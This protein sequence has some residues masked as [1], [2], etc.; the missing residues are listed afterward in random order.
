[1]LQ[2]YLPLSTNHAICIDITGLGRYKE[3]FLGVDLAAR[4]VLLYFYSNQPITS[5]QVCYTINEFARKKGFLP[6]INVIHSDR[7]SIFSNT[8]YYECIQSLGIKTSRGSAKAYQNQVVERLNRTIK[9]RLR[10]L[11]DPSWK[12]KREKVDPLKEIKYSF[13][14]F[15]SLVNKGIE[16]YN[17][18]PHKAL[19]GLSPNQ[20]EEAL[21]LQHKGNHP[22]D[23]QLITAND[24]SA[25]AVFIRQYKQEVAEKYKGKWERFFI[26]WR[27]KQEEFQGKVV[28][29]VKENEKIAR[30]RAQ[31]LL[32]QYE[33]L[34]HQ[35]L[36]TQKQVEL[37]HQQA[38]QNQQE[39]KEKEGRKLKR[40]QAKKQDLR[41]TIKPKEFELILSLVKGA[42]GF[43]ERRR[44]KLVGIYI[45][46]LRVSNL[47]NLSV[48][49]VKQ[50]IGKG[51]NHIS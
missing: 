6:Q 35:H 49:Q 4:N 10:L 1:M 11:L 20:M 21:F 38:L 22:K 15:S 23:L 29:Q 44:F 26:E 8:E 31:E 9:D 30:L 16:Q 7:G 46:G 33:N 13:Q 27:F 34:Y 47:L 39:R 28:E 17:Q 36:K 45:T 12:K 48:G 32:D 14:E 50:L 51:Q 24:D 40:K 43:K 37:L 2:Q 25:Q 5:T 19:S 41:Q 18:K 3:L 42:Y